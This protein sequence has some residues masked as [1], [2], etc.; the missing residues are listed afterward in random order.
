MASGADGASGLACAAWLGQGRPFGLAIQ[1][2][3]DPLGVSSPFKM[4]YVCFVDLIRRHLF[5]S[6]YNTSP[7]LSMLFL[8]SPACL[9]LSRCATRGPAFAGKG[10]HRQQ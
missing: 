5:R 9:L 6:F 4:T 1:L 10:G 2:L 8:I 7:L 3:A